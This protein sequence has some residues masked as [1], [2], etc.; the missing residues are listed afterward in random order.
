MCER[1]HLVHVLRIRQV[2]I[3]RAGN[4]P[5]LQSA[6]TVDQLKQQHELHCEY[7]PKV[8]SHVHRMCCLQNERVRLSLRD[9]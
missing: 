8:P 4:W 9:E 3:K 2:T 6:I 1:C 7:Q 5:T